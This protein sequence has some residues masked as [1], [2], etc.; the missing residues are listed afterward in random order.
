M[1]TPIS[2]IIRV[3]FH[4]SKIHFWMEACVQKSTCAKKC[5]VSPDFLETQ[6]WPI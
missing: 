6:K 4:I 5:V 3:A 2:L 1:L